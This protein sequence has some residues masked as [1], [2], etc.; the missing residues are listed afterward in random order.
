MADTAAKTKELKAIKALIALLTGIALPYER[1]NATHAATKK[2]KRIVCLIV[3]I[4]K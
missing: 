3:F 2:R 4:A 1:Q